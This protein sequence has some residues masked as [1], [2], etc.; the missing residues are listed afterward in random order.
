MCLGASLVHDKSTFFPASLSLVDNSFYHDD[1]VSGQES[2]GML[3]FA[4]NRDDE[5]KE[6]HIFLHLIDQT[7]HKL[8]LGEEGEEPFEV[9]KLPTLCSRIQSG[10]VNGKET[11]FS[12]SNNLRLYINDKLFSNECTCFQLHENFI[13][14]VNST[15][16]VL[17]NLYIYDLTRSLPKS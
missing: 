4:G 6:S 16:E 11:L 13:L 1:A 2:G 3:M 10:F 14:F 5:E 8:P 15:A 17:H 7:V 9:L 12:L